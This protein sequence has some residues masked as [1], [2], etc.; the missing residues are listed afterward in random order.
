MLFVTRNG[1][2][3]MEVPVE[4]RERLAGYTSLTLHRT[5]AAMFRLLV[6]L[7][8]VPLRKAVKERL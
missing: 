7:V 8:V 3:T 6:L 2:R 5:G 4:M 1:F